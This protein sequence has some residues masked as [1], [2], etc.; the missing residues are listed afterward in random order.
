MSY[1]APFTK[2]NLDYYL[3][4][5]AKEFRKRN[6]KALPAE[7]ILVGGASILINYGFREM[8][9]DMDAII[10]ASSAMK[11]AINFI[12]DQFELP[13]G[14]LNADVINTKSYTPKLVQYSK[15]Y[16]TYSNILNI[17]TI[18]SEY[19]IAMKLVSGRTFKNDLSDI[20]GILHAHHVAGH[21]ISKDQINKAVIDLYGTWDEIAAD[22]KDFLN[23][24]MCSPD[25]NRLYMQYLKE[26]AS[27]RD[28]LIEINKKTPRAINKD[29]I[30]EILHVAKQKKKN[31]NMER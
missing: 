16:R 2:E 15:H 22:T 27:N 20:V 17:R 24:V 18:S 28:M 31:N 6:G 14:W 23:A 7:I 21:P 9:Y 5:L 12:G 19:L 3:K 30:D 4:A 25:L 13:N 29:N 26:E 11:E 1:N 8:T 10:N